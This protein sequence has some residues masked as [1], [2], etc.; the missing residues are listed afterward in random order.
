MSELSVEPG[1]D[2]L[3]AELGLTTPVSLFVD[4]RFRVWRDI[5]ERQNAVLDAPTHSG[6]VRLHL[7]RDKHR[8]AHPC[9][10]EVRGLALLGAASIPCPRLVACAT[11]D[12]GRSAVITL[13]LAG[14]KP[15]DASGLTFDQI[16]EPT[17]G[18]VARLH[19]AGLH[20]RDLYLNHLFVDPQHPERVALLDAAR[21]RQLPRW[22]RR[23]WIVKDLAQFAYSTRLMDVSSD[24]FERWLA[25]YAELAS[26][27]DVERLAG[28]VERKKQWIARHDERLRRVAPERTAALEPR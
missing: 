18:L 3:L 15:A 12:D 28:E 19:S 4:A 17:A 5:R 7:K 8:L 26:V 13:D 24:A 20:H 16:A 10:D 2:A 21:V 11:L 25:R 27:S 22:F 23:R 14:M 6:P 9:R 1:F